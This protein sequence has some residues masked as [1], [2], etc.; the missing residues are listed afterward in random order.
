LQ[1]PFSDINNQIKAAA[2]SHGYY[3]VDMYAFMNT[4]SSGITF[5]G[6]DLSPKY[7]EG[8]A[9]SLDGLHPN[10]R[11][12]AMIANEFIKV[13]NLNFQSNLQTV[14]VGNYRG[15]TFP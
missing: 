13:I 7:I 14:S 8:G 6:V 10:S 4:F 2:T 11:G 15:I 9:F 12:Y 1:Q 3:V 5:D